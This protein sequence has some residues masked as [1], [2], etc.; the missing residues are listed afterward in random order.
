[1]RQHAGRVGWASRSVVA[2]TLAAA[3][4]LALVAPAAASGPASDPATAQFEITFMQH[5]T[6]HHLSAVAMAAVCRGKAV[7]Q[8]LRDACAQMATDQ[9][10][11]IGQMLH[12]LHHWYG[13]AHVPT[14]SPSD[15]Q[16]L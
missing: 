8:E 16:T 4:L 11:E 2:L 10:R 7:H 13:V 3:T 5:M 6:N 9:T 12:W 14:L 1:M 15:L